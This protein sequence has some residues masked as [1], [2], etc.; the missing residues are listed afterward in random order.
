MI[1]EEAKIILPFVTALTE[2][3]TIQ[4][5]DD[6]EKDIWRD[7]ENVNIPSILSRPKYYRIKPEPSYRPFKDGAECWEEMQK[8]EPFGWLMDEKLSKERNL[9]ITEVL[10]SSIT[11]SR[12]SFEGTLN[13][14]VAF[15]NLNFVDGMPFG[16]K[17]E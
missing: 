1:R 12:V 2:G 13:Y 16:K 15:M 8:H 5:C 6:Y 4:Y 11:L 17:E 10:D 9:V 3:K 14:D 7:L